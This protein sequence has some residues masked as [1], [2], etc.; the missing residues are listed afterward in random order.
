M[1]K[2]IILEPNLQPP[3]TFKGEDEYDIIVPDSSLEYFVDSYQYYKELSPREGVYECIQKPGE[4]LFIPYC[5]WHSVLNLEFSIAIT[6]NYVD[7]V[8][9]PSVLRFLKNREPSLF[10]KFHS[11][12]TKNYP[13]LFPNAMNLI[14]KD[15]F[16][17]EIESFSLF[18]YFK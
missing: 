5:Y 9:L 2:W 14:E 18:D 8:N 1:K 15:D 6:Q 3:N 10:E 12:M 13:H 4:L 16:K 17:D 11:E 7:Q